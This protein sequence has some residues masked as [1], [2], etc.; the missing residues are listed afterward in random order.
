M[1]TSVWTAKNVLNA[2]TQGNPNLEIVVSNYF[3]VYIVRIL[4]YDIHVQGI[5]SIEQLYQKILEGIEKLEDLRKEFLSVIEIFATSN[6]SLLTKYLPSFFENLLNAYEEQGINLLTG[7]SA[8][9]L[10]NDH[11]RFFNQ[12]LFISIVEKLLENKC[13]DTLKSILYARFKVYNRQYGMIRDV[14]FKRYREYNYTLNEFLN[15]ESNK[16]LS[17]TADYIRKYS[18]PAYF[19][20]LIKADILL[21]Y[22]SLWHQTDDIFDT[23]WYPEL[24]VYNH[25]PQILPF[26][27]SMS[28]FEKAKVIFGVNTIEEYKQLL[29]E[30][31]DTLERS[32]VYRVPS[33]KTGLLYDTVGSTE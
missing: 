25:Q 32:G 7:T 21:Y 23:N 14:N 8:D 6:D 20:R 33:L 5:S 28:Y 11:Y 12:F 27:V 19:E 1:N 16:R 29:S 31:A 9:V 3:K 22:I 18:T 15:T 13:F 10:R 26:M 24:S 4:D 17:V 2:I 30:T